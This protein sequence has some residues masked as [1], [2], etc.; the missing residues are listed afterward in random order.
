MYEILELVACEQCIHLEDDDLIV[1][2]ES[3]V[4]HLPDR[5]IDL[6]QLD[7]AYLDLALIAQMEVEFSDIEHQKAIVICVVDYL[8]EDG[9]IVHGVDQ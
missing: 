2:A 7:D 4:E 5:M 8:D 1:F 9:P 6:V 3:I